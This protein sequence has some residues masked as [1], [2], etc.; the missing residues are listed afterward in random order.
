MTLPDS[1]SPRKYT[2]VGFF[3]S[4]EDPKPM[5]EEEEQDVGFI[6]GLK[7]SPLGVV[8]RENLALGN[9]PQYEW[10]PTEEEFLKFIMLLVEMK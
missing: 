7:H 4:L 9:L 6:E 1:Y 5:A 3:A 8:I 2:P 10:K